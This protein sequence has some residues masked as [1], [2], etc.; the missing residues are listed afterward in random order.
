MRT[1]SISTII[2]LLIALVPAAPVAAS[3]FSGDDGQYQSID[4]GAARPLLSG[5]SLKFGYQTSPK[6][7]SFS[8][9]W[10]AGLAYDIALGSN[11]ALGLELQPYTR[12][13]SDS[14]LALDYSLLAVRSWAIL[15]GG[16]GLGRLIGFLKPIVVFAG[17]G[18]G[19]ETDYSK[20]T[21]EGASA[22]TT[23][24][25]FGYMGTLGL[26]LNLGS[27][28]LSAEYQFHMIKDANVGSGDWAQLVFI[29]LKF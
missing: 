4:A 29:G 21:W 13:V 10:F 19:G 1:R 12:S 15:K 8:N 16:L 5:F 9:A 7:N 28:A 22:S 14:A 2:A 11:F 6:A 24:F 20:V 3:G 27:A 17:A 26:R 25:H 18:A 23:A